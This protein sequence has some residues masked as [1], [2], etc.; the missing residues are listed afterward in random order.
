MVRKQSGRWRVMRHIIVDGYNVIR[1]NPRLQ[2]LESISLERARDVLVQTLASSPR[3]VHDEITV[4]FDGAHGMRTHVHRSRMGRVVLLYSARG[5]SADDVIID[6]ARRLASQGRVV[7][8]SNDVEVREHCRA[9]GSEVSSSENLLAQI[10]GHI[11][12]SPSSGDDERRPNLSTSKH[13][14]PHRSSRRSRRQRDIR[15]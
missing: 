13:G 12:P 14:N 6:E 4:V 7:V 5:Q 10:P 3:L 8:V 2:S 9:A 15:F 11:S 1:A